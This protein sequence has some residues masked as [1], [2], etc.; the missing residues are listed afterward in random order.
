MKAAPSAM[1]P[2]PSIEGTATG[3]PVSAAH[4]KRWASEDKTGRSK[5]KHEPQHDRDSAY[6]MDGAN[7]K[8]RIILLK[9]GAIM[10]Q[11]TTRVNPSEETITLG[12]LG[13]PLTLK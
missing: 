2:N 10:Q 13:L 3:K 11:R 8:C 1:T 5:H 12:P 4:V 9:R 6:T 7:R